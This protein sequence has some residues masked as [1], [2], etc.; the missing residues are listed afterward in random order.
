MALQ[1][2]IDLGVVARGPKG[3]DGKSAYQVWL[4]QG[5]NGSEADF[6]KAIQGKVGKDGQSA[7]QEWLAAGNQ[8]TEANFLASLKGEPGQPGKDGA[9]GPAGKGFNIVK[10]YPSVA[11]MN[12]Q[13]ASDNIAEG[14]FVA[15]ASKNGAEDPENAQVYMRSGNSMKFIVDLSGATGIQGPAGKTG[16][17]GATYQP[18]IA[19]D[20][21]WHVRLVTLDQRCLL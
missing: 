4:D 3:E 19:E 12:A 15:I 6:L 5:N 7:Y 8:G 9:Q 14:D 13:F 17:T 16:Q 21:N 20:G 10:T 18:Y 2:D 11:E 1:A